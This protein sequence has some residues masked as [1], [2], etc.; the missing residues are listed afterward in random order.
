[1][2]NSS[3]VRPSR[4]V[5]WCQ[6]PSGVTL[7]F[8]DREHPGRRFGWLGDHDAEVRR[9]IK[10]NADKLPHESNESILA[11]VAKSIADTEEKA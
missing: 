1:L 9:R 5:G 10:R 3:S 2:T 7:A 11:S 4:R 8:R 6:C